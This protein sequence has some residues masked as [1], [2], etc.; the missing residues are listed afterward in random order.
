VAAL[1]RV[2]A[3]SGALAVIAVAAAVALAQTSRA[4]GAAPVAPLRVH[5]F[6]APPSPRFGDVIAVHIVV[7]ADRRSIDTGE[8]RVT[9]D[10]SPLERLGVARTS[11]TTS[12]RFLRISITAD[13]VCLAEQCLGRAG[14]KRLRLPAV[15]A[16][17][18]RHGGG[19]VRAT[20]AWPLLEVRGRV[21]AA[22]LARSRLPFR[23]DTS[24]PPVTYRIRPITLAR[25]LDVLAVLLVGA[26]LVLAARQALGYTRRRRAIDRRSELERALELVRDAQTRSPRDRRLAVGLLARILRSHNAELARDAGD[27]AWSEPQPPPEALG[28]LAERAEST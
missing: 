2:G 12:G 8:L 1:T 26:G 7:L 4:I 17:A 22:D 13:T 19:A 5:A 3:A 9:Y 16:E 15:L 6:F 20:A 27:L 28:S 14:P 18:A 11:R 23:S 24:L 25:L 21:V 10:L